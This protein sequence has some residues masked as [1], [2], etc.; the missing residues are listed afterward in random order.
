MENGLFRSHFWTGSSDAEV[1]ATANVTSTINEAIAQHSFRDERVCRANMGL[2]LP[3]PEDMPSISPSQASTAIAPTARHSQHCITAASVAVD[4]PPV[5]PTV[6]IVP[7]VSAR[8]LWCLSAPVLMTPQV[9]RICPMSPRTIPIAA[10]PM[11]PF[12][13]TL[14]RDT[15]FKHSGACCRDHRGTYRRRG[16]LSQS[17]TAASKD[18]S[19]HSRR[20]HDCCTSHR[21]LHFLL[22]CS[23][24]SGMQRAIS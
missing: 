19:E 6:S 13:G 12:A 24:H 10:V 9:I 17:I 1:L 11:I 7:V 18:H 16:A 5:R 22:T 15:T 2:V 3:V 20:T 21:R 8:V 4:L 23:A 14:Q